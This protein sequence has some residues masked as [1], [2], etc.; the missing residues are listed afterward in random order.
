[1]SS[2]NSGH[3]LYDG[4][5]YS[6][7]YTYYNQTAILKATMAEIRICDRNNKLLCTHRRAY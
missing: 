5:Y 7:L 6:V 4:H 1:M 3:L 2:K